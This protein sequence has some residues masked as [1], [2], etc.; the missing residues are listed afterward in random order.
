[1][2]LF[3]GF[4]TSQV[5]QD[6][7][8]LVLLRDVVEP[9]FTENSPSQFPKDPKIGRIL[10]GFGRRNKPN[11]KWQKQKRRRRWLSARWDSGEKTNQ[12]V[13]TKNLEGKTRPHS[14]PKE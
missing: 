9:K 5:V 8:V 10:S 14:G 13:K 12:A 4:Y 7:S 1:M 3:T 6:F 2:P 11:K